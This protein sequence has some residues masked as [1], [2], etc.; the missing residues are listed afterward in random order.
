MALVTGRRIAWSLLAYIAVRQMVRNRRQRQ[1]T[2]GTVVITG[3]TRGLGRALVMGYLERGW[4]VAT[5]AR[6][7]DELDALVADYGSDR[8]MAIQAD[9]ADAPAMAGLVNAVARH[10]G[11]VDVWINNAAELVYGPIGDQT[12]EDYNHMLQSNFRSVIICTEAAVP[13]LRPRG[14]IVTVLSAA[15]LMPLSR[16]AAYAAAKSAVVKW[17]ESL[18]IEQG[19]DRRFLNVFLGYMPSSA[20]ERAVFR[21][22]KQHEQRHFQRAAANPW[23]A[24]PPARAARLIITAQYQGRHTLVAPPAVWMGVWLARLNPMLARRIAS[25][26][27]RRLAAAEAKAPQSHPST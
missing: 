5:C 12:P 4:N 14:Q 13:V 17:L 16:L 7:A 8:L 23:V 24:L 27:N 1:V 19:R 10:W 26:F 15:A 2:P 9:T 6:N 20:V 21:G 11:A 25:R 3:G 18:E 22:P